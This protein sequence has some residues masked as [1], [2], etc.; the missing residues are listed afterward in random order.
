MKIGIGLPNPVRGTSGHVLLEMARRAEERGFTGLATI[1]RIAYPNYDSLAALAAAAGATSRIGLQ[2]N[3][4]LGPAYQPI[5]LAK[6]AASIDQLSG[7]RLT[8]G[9]APGGRPDD[10]LAT[11]NDFHTRGRDLDAMVDVLHRAWRGE[12]VVPGVDQPVCPIPV[13]NQRVPILF[14]GGTDRSIERMVASGDGWTTGGGTAQMAAPMFAKARD[15]WRQAGRDG[16]PRLAALAY[17]S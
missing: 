12:H 13:N 1:D 15:A 16:E 7:G 11:G 8:L 10:Y 9:L 5:L 14:G 6:T 3:I 4:L 2:T 17:F